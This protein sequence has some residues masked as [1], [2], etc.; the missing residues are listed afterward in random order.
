VIRQA[1]AALREKALHQ[2]AKPAHERRRAVQNM[3]EFAERNRTRLQDV[4]IRELIHEGHRVSLE[5]RLP[6]HAA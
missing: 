5:P 1:L 3:L 2:A 4:S 6:L